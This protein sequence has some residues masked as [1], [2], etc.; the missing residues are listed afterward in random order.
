MTAEVLK[1]KHHVRNLIGSFF[2]SVLQMAD[3]EILTKNT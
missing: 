3:V 1:E 2:V